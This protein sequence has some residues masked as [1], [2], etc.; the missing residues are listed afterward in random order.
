[1]CNEH[2][3]RPLSIPFHAIAGVF[4]P[5]PTPRQA[6]GKNSFTFPSSDSYRSY[7]SSEMKGIATSAYPSPAKAFSAKAVASEVTYQPCRK[8]LTIDH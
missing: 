8:P 7:R 4:H 3:T 2:S 6:I 1:M 5:Q